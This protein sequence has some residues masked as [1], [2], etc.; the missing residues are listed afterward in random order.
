MCTLAEQFGCS[1]RGLAKV[2][3]RHGIP[4]PPRG[5]WAKLAAGH[6]VKRIKL[7][8]LSTVES[9]ALGRLVIP[10]GQSRT[11]TAETLAGEQMAVEAQPEKRIEVKVELR[12]PHPLVRRTKELFPSALED[13]RHILRPD[14]WR[15]SEPT[16]ALA[17]HVSKAA[18]PRA[19]RVADAVVKAM[20]ARGWE[21]RCPAKAE[22]HATGVRL[23]GEEVPISI[24]ER[25]K[26]FDRARVERRV[27]RG[28]RHDAGYGPY[29]MI[30]DDPY[31]RWDYEPLGVLQ[32]RVR[33]GYGTTEREIAD[34]A[35]Q[36]VEER[37]NEFM[38]AIVADAERRQKR[39]REW[40]ERER[41]R[42]EE[43]RRLAEEEHIR[44]EEAARLASL[45]QD[46]CDWQRAERIRQF[47]AAALAVPGELSDHEMQ[48]VEWAL[49]EADRIDPLKR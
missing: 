27:T 31:P 48:Y 15:S 38:V 42:E 18:I 25:V 26:R 10:V 33:S 24:D 21:I 47:M 36:R 22:T 37:L 14:G 12:N 44:A 28:L 16:G 49:A 40:A 3:A 19:L 6:R 4:V 43:A 17:I 34:G 7:P 39:A 1:D 9:D 32:L 41:L 45:E 8:I 46:A 30:L 5:Y 13:D 29:V 23:L 20:E 2:C 35:T 11:P